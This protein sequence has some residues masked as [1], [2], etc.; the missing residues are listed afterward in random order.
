MFPGPDQGANQGDIANAIDTL[1]RTH[2]VDVLNLSL[3]APVAS[4]IEQDAIRDALERG[5]LC[6]CAAA[7]SAGPVEFPAAFE[8]SAAVSALG[9]LGTAPS[10]TL[11]A[12][13]L[14]GG[15]DRFGDESLY[16]ANFSCFGPELECAGPGVAVIATVPARFGLEAPY[17]GMDGTSMASPAVC[18][19]LAVLLGRAP[20]YQ[21]LSRDISR[22]NL[23]RRILLQACR[24]VGLAVEFEGRG[25][26][27]VR[28]A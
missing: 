25:V 9:Q 4:G 16:L 22:A 27:S 26:P 5:T 21:S 19:A 8:E 14:P 3:G 20:D 23:A 15:P 18:G 6:V 11:S 13:R 28:G 12:S 17:A 7:N 10:G 24:D 1:S 2:Q